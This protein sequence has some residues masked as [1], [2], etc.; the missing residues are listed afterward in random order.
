MAGLPA[1]RQ[2]L[3][4][5]GEALG[6]AACY[7]LGLGLDFSLTVNAGPP[8][9]RFSGLREG[10]AH[11]LAPRLPALEAV[12][13]CG[14]QMLAH[15]VP[16]LERFAADLPAWPALPDFA[17]CALA[18]FHAVQTGTG[19]GLYRALFAQ[20]LDECAGAAL[21]RVAH[22]YRELAWAWGELATAMRL[23]S[24]DGAW[25][26]LPAHAAQLAESERALASLL[27]R[28]G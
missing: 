2:E 16:E 8:S 7:G 26:G 13:A 21:R 14:A 10:L 19:G 5:R 20:F 24:V 17:A 25:D 12:R 9:R 28:A 23:A 3:G 22:D 6:D 4:A 1:L 15:G 27:V 18:G 11:R